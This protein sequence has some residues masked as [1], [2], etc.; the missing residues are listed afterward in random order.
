MGEDNRLERYE[1]MRVWS[2][3]AE[4]LFKDSL[5]Q[6]EAGGCFGV[7]CIDGWFERRSFY[8]C[9]ERCVRFVAF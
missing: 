8:G 6:R 5:A 2:R 1:I 3:R 9:S 4:T 7:L